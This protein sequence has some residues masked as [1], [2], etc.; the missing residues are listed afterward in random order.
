MPRR[1]RPAA[2]LNYA[3]KPLTPDRWPD[4]ETVFGPSGGYWGCWC[5]YWRAPRRDFEGPQR[6]NMKARF[7]AR[8]AKGPPPGLIA[9]AEGEPVGWAQVGPRFDTPNWSA[10][11]RL[12]APP[13]DS[14]AFN[15]AFWG[16]N[17][18]VV[19]REWRG[20]GV[21]R[22]LVKAAVAFAKKNGARAL[23][24]CPV[25]TGAAD[26]SPVSLYHGTARMFARAGFVEIARRRADRPLMRLYFRRTK[27]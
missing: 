24:A 21:A 5:M 6:K 19:R 7:K 4:L 15:P 3:T 18:F 13:D 20:K 27:S 2:E 14:E 1:A 17:C 10:R 11:R 25:E 12:S 22:A 16:I 26:K 23:D 8:V 9:Y